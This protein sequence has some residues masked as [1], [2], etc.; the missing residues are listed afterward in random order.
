VATSVALPPRLRDQTGAPAEEYFATNASTVGP[1]VE[2]T[3]LVIKPVPK[4]TI[5]WNCP[6]TATLPVEFTATDLPLSPN[7][8][9]P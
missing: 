7:E 9:L 6:A 5:P 8:P 4:S 3:K 2:F 1:E